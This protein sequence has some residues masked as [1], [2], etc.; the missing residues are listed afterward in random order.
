M[1]T[2]TEIRAKLEP[3][4]PEGLRLR[5]YLTAKQVVNIDRTPEGVQRADVDAARAA[6]A[7][8]GWTERNAWLPRQGVS[9][10][11]DGIS[12]GVSFELEGMA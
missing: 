10:L 1:P 2:E 4:L 12:A 7:K 5:I 9:W 3:L 8:L 11:S 6:F